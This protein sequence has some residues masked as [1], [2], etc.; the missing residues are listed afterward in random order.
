MLVG[1]SGATVAAW[2]ALAAEPDEPRARATIAARLPT[3][4]ARL[5]RSPYGR[6]TLHAVGLSPRDLEACTDPDA[7]AA[8]PTLDRA[9]LAAHADE[10]A[11]F[12]DGDG[13][14]IVKSS[15]TTGDPVRVV[16]DHWDSLVMWA[17]LDHWLGV[18]GVLLPARPRVVLLDAL[19][20]GL[21][22]SVRLRLVGDGRGAL[23]RVSTGGARAAARL[24][25]VQPAV[26]FSDPDGLHWLAG[27]GAAPVPAPRL[28]LTSAQRFAPAQRAAFAAAIPGVPVINY[29]ATTETGPIAWECLAAPE[30]FHVLAPEVW[31]ESLEGELV[32]TRLRDSVL[33]L[34]RYRTG[35]AGDVEREAAR[36]CA[37]GFHGWSIVGF[38]GRRACWFVTPGGRSVD[39]WSLAWLFKHHPLRGFRL[40]QVA[41]AS[42]ELTLDDDASATPALLAQ[43]RDALVVQGWPRQTLRVSVVVEASAAAGA[44]TAAP[45]LK[46]EP[47]ARRAF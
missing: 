22:Y 3:L 39:A 26:L 5:W 45:P 21:E 34:L 18:L 28:V 2:R 12:A 4:A 31:V 43:L 24:A 35:D 11:A 6:A 13:A 9:T 17:A 42:F 23:H 15:G 14:V 44:G 25:R 16:K 41:P 19:P 36:G 33:P 20:G 10:L 46:P 32:V 40:L 47:F 8:F 38:G 27:G 30:R 29:Y 7:L 1:R 37:C